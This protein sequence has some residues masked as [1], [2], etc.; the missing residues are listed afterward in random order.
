MALRSIPPGRFMM[1]SAE[2]AEQ[3]IK[4]FPYRGREMFAGEG[5][6]HP[7]AIT[8][9]FYIGQYEVTQ[10]Q[11]QSFVDATAYQTDP[12]RTK[13]GG[14]GRTQAGDVKQMA[15][16]NWRNVGP[17]QERDWPVTNVSF[18]D[19]NAFCAWLSQKEGKR[20]RLP[21]EAEWEYAC[22]AEQPAA[23][24]TETIPGKRR[25]SPTWLSREPRTSPIP[26]ATCRRINS[27]LY[28]MLGNAAEWCA[29]WYGD[30]YYAKSPG[31]ISTRTVKRR[32]ACAPR[33]QLVRP[34]GHG[35]VCGVAT[36]MI[37]FRASPGSASASFAK[38]M[39]IKTARPP[40]RPRR[41]RYQ[42][43]GVSIRG[44]VCRRFRAF[45]QR[46]RSGRLE[47]AS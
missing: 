46:T 1:G 16:F 43:P 47:D 12:E 10:N 41:P 28:K 35:A 36:I 39:R 15:A 18:N 29:D 7:V 19:A 23:T 45:V 38:S 2:T 6:A 13:R 26:S 24:T 5:P 42:P 44:T 27:Y 11:F 3:L 40:Q 34:T 21:T 8:R 31:P 25:R 32:C 37:P 17:R 20:Y 22:R 14:F 30:D 9:P 4:A 33:R